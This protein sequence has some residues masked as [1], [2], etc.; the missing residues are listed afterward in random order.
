MDSLTAVQCA[1]QNL[2]LVFK[3]AI[4][5]NSIATDGSDFKIMGPSIVSVSAAAGNCVNGLTNIINVSLSSAIVNAGTYKII[6]AK[7]S[8]GNTIIDDCAQESTEGSSINFSV[9]DTVS[10]D[11]TFKLFKGCKTDTLQLFHNA[12]NEVNQFAW[13]MDY[14]GKSNQQNPVTYF[15][16]FGKKQITLSVSNGFCSDTAVKIIDLGDGIKASFE[17]N[18]LLCPEDPATFLNKST[19]EIV[20]YYWNFGNGNSSVQKDPPPQ[21]YPLS[22]TE[23]SYAVQL[24]VNDSTNCTDTAF[25]TLKVLK[26]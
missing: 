1:P 26:S 11:F 14:N 22:A 9:K 15:S 13:Q 4:R 5:C 17:T 24:I 16:S 23:N 21:T 20:S 25:Q 2:Q 18:N 12:K 6:L 3:K 8:D 7:G 10:A 19:G